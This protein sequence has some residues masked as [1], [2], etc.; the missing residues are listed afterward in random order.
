MAQE[1]I[2]V[3]MLVKTSLTQSK[4]PINEVNVNQNIYSKNWMN[5]ERPT[6]GTSWY[7]F[8][9]NTGFEAFQFTRGREKHEKGRE[10]GGKGTGGGRF[11]PPCPP[12]PLP[13][14]NMS[15]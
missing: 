4:K 14:T 2:K 11:W 12:P 7:S 5:N 9:T 13:P 10:A 8:M 15:F 6:N 1:Q 3:F